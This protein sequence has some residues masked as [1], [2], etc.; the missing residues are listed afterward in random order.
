MTVNIS[1]FLSE[2]VIHDMCSYTDMRDNLD[3]DEMADLHEMMVVKAERERRAYKRAEAQREDA[4]RG[5]SR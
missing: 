2:P 4:Q 5:G 1:P 3:I